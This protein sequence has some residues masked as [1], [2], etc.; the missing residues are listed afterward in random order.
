MAKKRKRIA[1]AKAA[2][3]AVKRGRSAQA[4]LEALAKEYMQKDGT[5]AASARQRARD[6]M[7]DK[8][9]SNKQNQL[10]KKRV[11]PAMRLNCDEVSELWWKAYIKNPDG[12]WT[13]FWY[14]VSVGMGC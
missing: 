9:Y 1:K 13:T 6:E 11:R 14:G 12:F 3:K 10:V 4:R 2:K 8:A 7:R 5:D